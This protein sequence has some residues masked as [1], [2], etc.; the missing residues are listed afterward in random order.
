M[1]ANNLKLL[2]SLINTVQDAFLARGAGHTPG[3]LPTERFHLLLLMQGWHAFAGWWAGMTTELDSLTDRSQPSAVCILAGAL[4]EAALV[5]VAE[6][7]RAAGEWRNKF[8]KEKNPNRWNL[9]ELVD[10][11]Q[12]SGAFS[13]E[14][15]TLAREIAD[16][17]NRIHAGKFSHSGAPPFHPP[18]TNAHEAELA[19]LHLQRLIDALLSFGPV[20]SLTNPDLRS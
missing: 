16:F 8:L 4:L 11:A 1:R 15:A 2:R 5:A 7:C 10:Q 14:Q 17:R 20:A 3:R 12:V 9:G 13:S 18:S 19:R 6:P